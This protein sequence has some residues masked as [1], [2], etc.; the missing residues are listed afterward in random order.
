MRKRYNRGAA[1][2]PLP[3]R[4]QQTLTRANAPV[5]TRQTN[6]RPAETTELTRKDT[7]TRPLIWGVDKWG[8]PGCT[9]G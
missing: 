9:W 1:A 7:T 8:A 4:P 3:G 6:V 5:V 2:E